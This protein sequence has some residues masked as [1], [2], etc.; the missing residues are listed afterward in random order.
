[1]TLSNLWKPDVVIYH[2][3]CFDGMT[4]AWAV[5]KKFGDGGVTY[6]SAD[7]GDT[8]PEVVGKDVL[9]VDFSYSKDVLKAMGN[10]ANSVV[11]LD[12]HATSEKNLVE[13]FYLEEARTLP[14]FNELISEHPFISGERNVFA[15]FDKTKSGAR[16]AWDFCFPEVDPPSLIKW[17]E[18]RDLW[19]FTYP[20]TRAIGI[21]LGTTPMDLVSYDCLVRDLEDPTNRAEILSCAKAMETLFDKN[22]KDFASRAEWYPIGGHRVI[23]VNCPL[24]YRSEVGNYLAAQYPES[25]FS[26]T[27]YASSAGVKWSLRSLKGKCNVA[28]IAE[29]Y[30]GGGHREAAGFNTVGYVYS[31]PVK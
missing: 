3:D 22:V 18:D 19:K 27:F 21:F 16:L 30:Q 8:P 6:T 9:I 17:V 4:A 29:H 31:Q 13:D 26:A 7:Y 28:E 12:H 23:G 20:E 14:L 11:I 15:Y 25:L 5:W 24:E 2:R 10:M 1:M